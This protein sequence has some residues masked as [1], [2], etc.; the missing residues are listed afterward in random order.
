MSTVKHNLKMLLNTL[1]EQNPQICALYLFG[2]RAYQT[3]STRSD[4]DILVK[5]EE[6]N[7]VKSH[8]LRDFA[9]EHCAALDFFI[10]ISGHA[11]SCMNDSFVFAETFEQ[12]VKRLDA[13]ELWNKESG[14]LSPP[15][16][17]VFETSSFTEFTPTALPNGYLGEMSWQTIIKKTE[18][19]EL[20]TC[21]YIGDSID[22]VTAM[23]T[24]VAKRMILKPNE[25][26][27]RGAA[28]DGWT[29]NLK[30][31][32][33]CQNLFYTVIKPWIPSIGKEQV[34]IIYDE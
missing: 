17:W 3:G 11:T 16:E 18:Q 4:C 21:P 34:T 27:K 1:L 33:D 22:K 5:V 23:I 24:D 19:L 15:V 10:A 29:V 14:F 20:P 6:G 8:R 28:R 2:S 9:M 13:I 12:L 31:E 26:V 25:L 7:H 32:Y 30:S